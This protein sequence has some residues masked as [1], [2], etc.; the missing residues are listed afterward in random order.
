MKKRI[1]KKKK[2]ERRKKKEEY[3]SKEMYTYLQKNGDSRWSASS[4]LGRATLHKDVT[5]KRP[6]SENEEKLS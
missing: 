2:E 4:W 5:A 1:R 6:K 3:E